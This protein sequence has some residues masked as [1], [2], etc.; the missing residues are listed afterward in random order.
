MAQKYCLKYLV[1]IKS[2]R[3]NEDGSTWK[4][5]KLQNINVKNKKEKKKNTF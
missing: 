1:V 2:E 5:T 4:W 3:C